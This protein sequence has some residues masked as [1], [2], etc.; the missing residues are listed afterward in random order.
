[1]PEFSAP[2][3]A[4]TK[5]EKAKIINLD[6]PREMPIDCLFNPNEYT[7]AKRNKWNKQ[8]IIGK[9]VPQL[10]FG[11]GDSMTLKM[12]LFFDTYAEAHPAEPGHRAPV[13]P[14]TSPGGRGGS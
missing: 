8:E 3:Q 7:F 14:G 12:Q 11:G 10:Q 1:M 9:N 6:D 5:P 13:L 2:G 4:S